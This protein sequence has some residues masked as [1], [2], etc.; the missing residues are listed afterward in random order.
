MSG[1]HPISGLTPASQPGAARAHKTD[2]P[3][4]KTDFGSVVRDVIDE[5]DR[6][7]QRSAVAIQDLIA[8]R[9]TDVLSVVSQVAN[10]DLSFKLLIGVR[11]K[12]IE[13]Y[14]QTMN[15]QI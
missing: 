1:I 3:A 2:A 14:K 7:Q 10:A 13:A 15:M 6:D 8:G 12:M 4:D 5:V 11:N 9:S